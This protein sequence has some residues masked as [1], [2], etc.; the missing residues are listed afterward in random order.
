[1]ESKDF[2]ADSETGK[3]WIRGERI[4][5]QGKGNNEAIPEMIAWLK[6][7]GFK[8]ILELGSGTGRI[9]GKIH[10]TYP[11]IKCEGVD[12]N[13]LLAKYVK[14]QHNV[15]VNIFD[16]YD[17]LLKDKSFD[18]VYT[19]QVLQH[20][21]MGRMTKI[22]E[23]MKRIAKKEIWIIE[24]WIDFKKHGYFNGDMRHSAGGGT[25]YWEFERFF[26]C[27]KTGFLLKRPDKLKWIK[28]YKIKIKDNK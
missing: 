8:S 6:D 9:I 28:Y 23:E 1:M 11:K 10:K 27:Y 20:V 4:K 18:L 5:Y 26:K 16:I 17:M 25:F 14:K 21:P 3:K 15:K 2:W 22:I 7:C 12:I 13:P 19:F 24:G